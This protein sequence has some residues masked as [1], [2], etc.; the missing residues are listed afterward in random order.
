M[1]I[2]NLENKRFDGVMCFIKGKRHATLFVAVTLL[3]TWGA[4]SIPALLGLDFENSVTK[5]A[6]VLGGASPSIVGLIF[7]FLSDD[8]A[9]KRCFFC[10]IVGLG[11]VG[12]KGLAVLFALVPAVTVLSAYL[13]QLFTSTPPD[14]STLGAYI[15]DPAGLLAFAVFTLIFGPFA[16]EIG[17][18]GYLLD[19]WKDK[20]ILFY[21]AGIG[22]I[23]TIWHL[24]MFFINGTYQNSLLM[25]GV[26]PVLCFALS[27][28]ALGVIIGEIA[29]R[30]G[31]ILPAILFH[32]TINFTGE[33]I[34]LTPA[35]EMI[36]TAAFIVIALGMIYCHYIRKGV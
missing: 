2:E 11:K 32:F 34:P 9:Y 21:G 35:A 24:P 7:V 26:V 23:W 18:R 8:I 33:L 20:G 17:W 25:H 10:R 29:K 3:W 15:N 14:W 16:E 31:S 4:L 5:A 28:V 12:G 6:Y 36:R 30:T 13:N 22:F 19:C 27:T 1:T